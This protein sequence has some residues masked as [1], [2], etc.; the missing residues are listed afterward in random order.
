M[1]GQRSKSG[2]R[3]RSQAESPDDNLN[4]NRSRRRMT[5]EGNPSP[6]Q[7]RQATAARY[8]K[9]DV[10][11]AVVSPPTAAVLSAKQPA[12]VVDHAAASP[13]NQAD[14]RI[15]PRMPTDIEAN[16]PVLFFGFI[17]EVLVDRFFVMPPHAKWDPGKD[18][19]DFVDA[20]M[21]I[22]EKSKQS[23]RDYTA[24]A[25]TL[26]KCAI[27][28]NDIAIDALAQRLISIVK[29]L[30]KNILHARRAGGESQNN[31]DADEMNS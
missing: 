15:K 6:P 4:M 29:G 18:T 22:N 1:T 13:A 9:K 26:I 12:L 7:T 2:T 16:S 28:N 17:I 20:A 5:T 19:F 8:S 14:V 30:S 24:M 3:K 23:Q 27:Q 25:V 31:A 11:P 21:A 10:P